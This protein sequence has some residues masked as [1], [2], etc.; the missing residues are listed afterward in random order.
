MDRLQNFIDGKAVEP[1]SGEYTDVIDPTTGEAF[2]QAPLS[3]QADVDAAFRSAARAFT[4]WKRSTPGERS[5]LL[6][7]IADALEARKDEFVE[8]EC[9]N[10]GKPVAFVRDA[11]FPGTIEH[12][13]FYAAAA[14]DLRGLA[15]GQFLSG[16]ESTVRREPVGVCGLVSPWNYPLNMAVWKFGPALAAGNTVVLKPSDTTPVTSL[17]AAGIIGEILPPGVLNVIAG[18]RETGRLIVAHPTPELISITG[19]ERAGIEV[20]AAAAADLKRVSLELGGK[21]PV[22]VFEDVDVR[23][24]AEAIAGA[25]FLNAGQDCEAACRVL[26]A[27]VVHDAFVD[28]LVD[29]A[30]STAYGP[31]SD[32]DATY[33]PLNSEAQLTK[34][35]SFFT[36]LPAHAT[37]LTGGKADRAGGGYYFE[38]TVVADVQQHDRIVQEEVFGPVIT[39]QRFSSEDEAVALAN[40]VRFGLAAGLWTTNHDRVLRV[41]A[42]LDFGKVWVNCHLEVA[43]EMPNTGYKHSGHGNDLSVLAIEEYTRVKHV[44]SAVAPA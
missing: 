9:R 7:R 3:G 28:A 34:V 14:R 8:A 36:D 42:D 6:F 21:A 13:R 43:A 20:S 40:D 4:T 25:G 29:A 38:P 17:L 2:V 26:V 11:E 32:P 24:A 5:L 27:D 1:L 23:R 19:S 22:L 37:V 39:V 33:G 10:T 18:T 15:G 35:E 16:F 31:P 44:M 41:G 30:K 12:L